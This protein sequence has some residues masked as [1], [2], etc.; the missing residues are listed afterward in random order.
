M[1]T[2]HLNYLI[3]L[4]REELPSL[5]H[6]IQNGSNAL[7]LRPSVERLFNIVSHLVHNE[8]E[9]GFPSGNLPADLL[10]P[11]PII[12]QPTLSPPQAPEIPDITASDVPQVVVTPTGTRV[13]P[14]RGTGP[15]VMLPPGV[16]VDLTHL[17]SR[18][19]PPAA[20]PGVAQVVLPPGGAL[21][22]EAAAAL[23]ARS[24]VPAPTR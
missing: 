11:P 15:A 2:Q 21:S 14:P 20:P 1:N 8:I 4:V 13:I 16:A 24:A 19:E 18:P 17:P 6:D 23:A 7:A 22:P 3:Q 5:Q 9:E 10:V 12:T